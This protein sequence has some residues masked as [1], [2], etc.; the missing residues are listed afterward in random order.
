MKTYSE[1]YNNKENDLYAEWNRM[2][3]RDKERFAGDPD[4]DPRVHR[5]IR[6][7]RPLSQAAT[8]NISPFKNI[9][10]KKFNFIVNKA[11]LKSKVEIENNLEEVFKKVT[12]EKWNNFLVYRF[13]IEKFKTDETM[14]SDGRRSADIIS[15]KNMKFF[16]LGDKYLNHW[17]SQGY[18]VYWS[19]PEKI[20][21]IGYFDFSRW[22]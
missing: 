13:D 17:M 12:P 4:V 20:I 15:F 11:K 6:V 2:S 10:A 21:L 8:P 22:D 9:L 16:F 3:A 5:N 7:S 19:Y 18:R 1:Y 14:A